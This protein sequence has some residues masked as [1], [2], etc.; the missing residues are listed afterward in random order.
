VAYGL[1]DVVAADNHGDSRS[2]RTAAEFL[3]VNGGERMAERLTTTNPGA[4]LADG[5]MEP[6]EPISLKASW[7][8]R[9]A[10]LFGE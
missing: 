7:S 4:V 5:E 1:A 8:E 3:K 9:I 2:V 10:R 6:V